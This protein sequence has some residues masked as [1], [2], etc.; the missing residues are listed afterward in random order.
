MIIKSSWAK[1][2]F[3]VLL[4]LLLFLTII[5]YT[6]VA[7]S[8]KIYTKIVG[9]DVM[10]SVGKE[11][12]N[13][14]FIQ[15]STEILKDDTTG[16]IVERLEPIK[17]LNTSKEL[18][19]TLNTSKEREITLFETQ[20]SKVADDTSLVSDGNPIKMG[21]NRQN[22]TKTDVKPKTVVAN[23]ISTAI[24]YK[25]STTLSQRNDSGHEGCRSCFKNNF[26]LIINE[27]SFC[28]RLKNLTV[29]ILI[30]TGPDGAQGRTAV[31]ETWGTLCNVENSIACLFVLGKRDDVNLHKSIKEESEKYNDIIQFDFKDSY[32]NLTY[33]TMSA[34][35]WATEF[36]PEAQYV[37]KT[38]TDVY[39]NTE[40]LSKM[41]SHGAPRTNFLGG[42]CWTESNPQRSRNSKWYVSFK[43]YS[44]QKFP[45][46]CSGTGYILSKDTVVKLLQ[47]SRNIPFFH[48]EDVYVAL[49]MQ[50]LNIK[51]MYVRG[52][53]HMKTPFESCKYRNEVITSHGIDPFSLRRHWDDSRKCPLQNQD[54]E[55][56]FVPLPLH[57]P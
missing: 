19:N 51:P 43:S 26:A 13:V 5:S 57:L 24:S 9:K 33:K 41:L 35:R 27:E 2:F 4:I 21:D 44:R 14:L 39:V 29:L 48:L 15:N 42:N 47:K 36:C 16:F 10:L 38:D 53:Y 20:K 12:F 55:K 22:D 3:V 17:P 40:I 45:P 7:N 37:M 25:N 32:S 6:L 54:P 28:R 50:K 46:M 23:M 56:L 1:G 18:S 11:M 30:S 34:L 31:R 8:S 52:F 49:C